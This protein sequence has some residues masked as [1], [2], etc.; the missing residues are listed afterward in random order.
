MPKGWPGWR[1]RS[2]DLTSFEQEK[3][4][5]INYGYPSD[6]KLEQRPG[7]S[8]FNPI[9]K[10][11]LAPPP[12]A[13]PAPTNAS[14][15]TEIDIRQQ[16]LA[17]SPQ[18]EKKPVEQAF[19]ATEYNT[20]NTNGTYLT[21]NTSNLQYP[22]QTDINHL[23]YL[24]SL[25]SGFGDAEIN[26]PESGPTKPN[27]QGVRQ[28]SHQSRKFS[29]VS[30][31]PGFRRQGDRDTVYTTTSED[32]APRFRTVTSWVAQQTG[33]VERK[34]Q[35]DSEIPNIPTIPRPLQIGVDENDNNRTVFQYHPGDE[36]Q[37]SRGSRVP[38]EILDRKIG[39]R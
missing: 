24:S 14:R 10:P 18:Q 30:S 32:S 28:S 16:P 11:I 12:N 9:A 5:D 2:S 39:L 7:E 37:I 6:E 34:Q 36:V 29:W 33:R 25:S 35:I 22:N 13:T 4:S 31:V 15:Q 23:S 20:Y 8:F 21:Q 3:R 38:S 27:P 19:Y 17:V 1:R 26:I